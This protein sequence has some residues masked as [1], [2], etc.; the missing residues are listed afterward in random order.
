MLALLQDNIDAVS[1]HVQQLG[2]TDSHLSRLESAGEGNMNR[3]LRAVLPGGDSIVLKQAVDH[4]A[5]YPQ[6][7]AP[8]ERTSVEAAF[9]AVVGSDPV[10]AESMP[11][12]I[13]YD[14]ENQLMCLQYLD[15][16][17]DFLDIYSRTY[18]VG[19]NP[20]RVIA[21]VLN[22]LSN[23]HA[24]DPPSDFPDNLEMR[25]LNHAHIFDI[26]LRR[27][28]PDTFGIELGPEVRKLADDIY[29]DNSLL[30]SVHELGDVYLGKS[31]GGGTAV[32]LHGDFYPGSW[33]CDA[34][35]TAYV[36]DAEFAFV[37]PA[38][39]DVGV[40]MAHMRFAGHSQDDIDLA[41]QHY[42]E[43]G[44]FDQNLAQRFAGVEL[45]RR[46]LGVAQLPVS[47]DDQTR[48]SWIVRGRELL[49]A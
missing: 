29:N 42:A 22:W 43:P 24:L 17:S 28:T 30:A 41:L 38:E 31:D 36:I 25:K 16:S 6:I 46:L 10:L 47:R 11:R 39:F 27:E 13:A 12:F 19:S 2:W 5:K 14:P 15:D 1:A 40:F 48:A 23:L 9:Y 3:T 7:A 37:G 49:N 18:N 21:Q 45:L 26:P 35:N 33:L 32:L 44:G 20:D 4:V 8:I 34:S